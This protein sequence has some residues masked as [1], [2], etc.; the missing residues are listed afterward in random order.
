MKV[1][2]FS[3]YLNHHQL[4][5]CL[6]MD[7]L[8]QGQFTFVA[9][10]RIGDGRLALG[11]KDMD[12]QYPFVLTTYDDEEN[13][14]KARQLARDCDVV[15]TGSAPEVYTKIRIAEN[16]LTFRYSERI[17]RRGW[18]RAFAPRGLAFMLN[19]HTRYRK[20]ALYM[21][22]ASAY[23]AS[24]YS[25]TGSYIN[26]TF[27]W[28][29]FPEVKKQNIEKLF[30]RKRNQKRVTLLWV[31]RLIPLKHP[32]VVVLLAEKLKKKG[33]D[34]ELILIGSG[35]MEAKLKEIIR[36]KQLDDCVSMLGA[37]PPESVRKHMEDADIFLFTSDFREG[38]GAVLNEAMNSACAIVASHAIGS[39]PFLLEDGKNGYIYRN[40]DMN[41]LYDRTVRLIESPE[42]REALGKSA[43]QT[44]S[45]EW[46]A[47]T[48]AKR[49]LELSDALLQ[50]K[51]GVLYKS[52]PC[53]KARIIR[54]N[55]F[56]RV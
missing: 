33:Y 24:D 54:N 27:K 49:L 12:K 8:T 34:F 23:T 36:E 38:W 37:M 52:G 48:A 4:P 32:D 19:N 56:K 30:L 11:Y 47:D 18:W 53:S 13:E 25:I 10:K 42:L 29:Y 28:G 16:K 14:K 20:K 2:F 6:A 7:K 5:F 43:Y 3:N 22:C 1:A 9:T 55:W 45:D 40:G 21:L 35:E 41:S 26:K 46:N 51:D 17:Y 44:L 15:I 39:V 31:A 50:G